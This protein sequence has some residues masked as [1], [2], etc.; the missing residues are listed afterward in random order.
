MKTYLTKLVLP[1]AKFYRCD[2]RSPVQTYARDL[3]TERALH[4]CARAHPW[5][6]LSRRGLAIDRGCPR[7]ETATSVVKVN[8]LSTPA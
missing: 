8:I 7:T 6:H 1:G 2:Y 3:P 4:P 5:A